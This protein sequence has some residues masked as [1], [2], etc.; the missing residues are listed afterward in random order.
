MKKKCLNLLQW[1][2]E[3][4]DDFTHLHQVDNQVKATLW[5]W[6]HRVTCNKHQS[7]VN[8]DVDPELIIIDA[9]PFLWVTRKA[10]VNIPFAGNIAVGAKSPVFQYHVATTGQPDRRNWLNNNFFYSAAS[11][12]SLTLGECVGEI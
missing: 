2:K 6:D 5:P 8:S 4:G 7:N 11:C 10:A 1:N 3:W 12:P 9:K